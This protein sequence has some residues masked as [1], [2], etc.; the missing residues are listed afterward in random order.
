MP[1]RHRI[2]FFPSIVEGL[3]TR[4]HDVLYKPACY[5]QINLNCKWVWHE[6]CRL[7]CHSRWCSAAAHDTDRQ[8]TRLRELFNPLSLQS[9]P[10]W[11][12]FSCMQQ[13]VWNILKQPPCLQSFSGSMQTLIDRSETGLIVF[14]QYFWRHCLSLLLQSRR[15]I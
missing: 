12:W 2:Q 3:I 9:L 5:T 14:T 4:A 6:I 13:A 7:V 11:S 1:Q 15:L 10:L 8:T